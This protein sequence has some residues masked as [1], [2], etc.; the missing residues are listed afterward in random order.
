MKLVNS[1]LEEVSQVVFVHLSRADSLGRG[2][3][4]R[5]LLVEYVPGG[6]GCFLLPAFS[7]PGLDRFQVL[8]ALAQ[9]FLIDEPVVMQ[10]PLTRLRPG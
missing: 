4:Y 6:S 8:L 3:F 10:V 7:F 9:G 2:R 1:F 5:L